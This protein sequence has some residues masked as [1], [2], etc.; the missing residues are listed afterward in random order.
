[1]SVRGPLLEKAVLVVNWAFLIE[2]VAVGTVVFSIV[3]FLVRKAKIRPS[4]LFSR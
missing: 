3:L 4:H 2:A 1:V